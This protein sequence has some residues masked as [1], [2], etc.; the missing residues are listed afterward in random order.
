MGTRKQTKDKVKAPL[1]EIIVINSTDVE[2][3]EVNVNIFT[4]A[5]E[6]ERDL[7]IPREPKLKKKRKFMSWREHKA[8]QLAKARRVEMKQGE[9]KKNAISSSSKSSTSKEEDQFFVV[10]KVFY[11]LL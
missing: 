7:V 6:K 9:E 1:Q 4:K 2:D 8:K 10:A 11:P 3:Q 5:Q